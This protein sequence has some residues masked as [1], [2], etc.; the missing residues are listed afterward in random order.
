MINKLI[1]KM[2]NIS[3][4]LILIYFNNIT[5]FMHKTSDKIK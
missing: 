1:N 3:L 4:V 2:T 5:S